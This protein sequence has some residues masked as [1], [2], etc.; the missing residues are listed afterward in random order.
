M[1]ADRFCFVKSTRTFK[2][3]SFCLCSFSVHS[4]R[5]FSDCPLECTESCDRLRHIASC[6]SRELVAWLVAALFW[7][8]MMNASRLA[9]VATSLSLRPA[10]SLRAL[11]TIEG[12]S[13]RSVAPA[14]GIP[15]KATPP[16]KFPAALRRLARDGSEALRP[17]LVLSPY[18]EDPTAIMYRNQRPVALISSEVSE[19][20]DIVK[21]ASGVVVDETAAS[22]DEFTSSE[23]PIG[24][25]QVNEGAAL[26]SYD[27]RR[28]WHKPKVSRRKAHVLRKHAIR[29]GSYGTFDPETGTGWD[30]SWDADLF[31]RGSVGG[32]GI[33]SSSIAD[34]DAATGDARQGGGG[35]GRYRVTVPK[36]T[37]RQRTREQRAQLI[38]RNMA[39]MDTRIDEYYAAKHAA[40]PP[41]TFENLHKRL[42]RVKK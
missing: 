41:D 5:N 38:D 16:Q 36:R 8:A 35:L 26:S 4:F 11:S 13:V 37:N 2:P 21:A 1:A 18:P 28:C 27:V 10:S 14:V 7:H 31:Q 17:K 3:D 42:M 29:T 25:E 24:E 22:S 9:R 23:S 32:G 40:K 34:G 19:K 20:D 33:Q 6:R 15:P 30:A 39:D 12:S